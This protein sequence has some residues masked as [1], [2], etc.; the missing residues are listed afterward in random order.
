[1][2][3]EQIEPFSLGQR[4]TKISG[5][6]W[7]GL[8]WF[9]S[10]SLTPVGICVESENEPGSVQIY[11]AKALRLMQRPDLSGQRPSPS[12][13]KTMNKTRPLAL[14][15]RVEQADGPNYALEQ[16]IAE[17]VWRVKWNKARPRKTYAFRTTRPASTQPLRWCRMGTLVN[18][19]ARRKIAVVSTLAAPKM[20][21]LTGG[22]GAHP[23]LGP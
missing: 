7:T 23:A 5:S 9:Y 13:I 22:D 20:A 18:H 10:T 12:W 3:P 6:S 1:M 11:P 2:T 17:A 14:A 16:D 15:E 4:V 8:V 21:R 19:N